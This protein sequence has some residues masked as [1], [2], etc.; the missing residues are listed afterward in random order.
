MQYFSESKSGLSFLEPGCPT[1]FLEINST[2][3]QVFISTL[4]Q[5]TTILQVFI[6]TLIQHTTI[7]QVFISTLIQHTTILQ[8]FISTL[9]QHTTILQV[10][11]ST[12]IQHTTILQVFISTLI[13]HTWSYSLAAQQYISQ[14]NEMGFVRVGVNTCRIEDLQERG[15]VA[16]F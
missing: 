8:V 14:L 1:L 15:W 10:F 12:L 6:S 11:I 13:Q 3:L 5:H 7:L 16:L 2:I 9:I 4:I